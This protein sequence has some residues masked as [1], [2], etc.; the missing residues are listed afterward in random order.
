[1]QM[2][3]RQPWV[4]RVDNQPRPSEAVWVV[5]R[6]SAASAATIAGAGVRRRPTC[7]RPNSSRWSRCRPRCMGP[8]RGWGCADGCG[9]PAGT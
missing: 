8:R 7:R 3:R 5:C 2:R 1:M 6:V 4:C 9:C